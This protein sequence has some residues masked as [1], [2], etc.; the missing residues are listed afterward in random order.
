MR[1]FVSR[2]RQYIGSVSYISVDQS[3]RSVRGVVAAS[4]KG[5]LAVLDPHDGSLGES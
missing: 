1:C 5:V 3:A 2:R 4:E